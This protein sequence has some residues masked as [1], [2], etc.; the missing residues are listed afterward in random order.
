MKNEHK[1]NWI[2]KPAL[3]VIGLVI[4]FFILVVGCDEK[5]GK[6]EVAASDAAVKDNKKD[7]VTSATIVEKP[8]ENKISDVSL[9]F[10]CKPKI[11][12]QLA[13]PKSFD[14][15]TTSLKYNFADNQHIIGFD[16][17]AKNS[18]GGEIMQQAICSF[19]VDGNILEYGIL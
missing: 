13:N 12:E 2:R 15:S 1:L 14:P 4:L 7:V 17:Y 8:K 19:D 11:Q 10:A 5:E 16:F 6:A 18:F 9:Y 3:A